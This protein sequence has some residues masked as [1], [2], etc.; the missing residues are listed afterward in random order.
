MYHK[1]VDLVLEDVK[2]DYATLSVPKVAKKHGVSPQFMRKFLNKNGL[3]VSKKS[4]KSKK[5]KKANS[6]NN[7]L[8]G[9]LDVFQFALL[10]KYLDELQVEDRMMVLYNQLELMK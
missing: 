7:L 4:K 2:K 10:Q 5:R 6:E 9:G 3:F 1:T 8:M